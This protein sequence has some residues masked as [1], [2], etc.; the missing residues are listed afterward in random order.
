MCNTP[1]IERWH[2][3]CLFR[4]CTM[5]ITY[6]NFLQSLRKSRKRHQ[7]T[8][9]CKPTKQE[10]PEIFARIFGLLYLLDLL[11]FKTK[12]YDG[13]INSKRAS[14]VL[15]RAISKKF[16]WRRIFITQGLWLIYFSTRISQKSEIIRKIW[17]KCEL[18]A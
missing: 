2:K 11:S 9:P 12:L 14:L 4:G 18:S 16:R 15:K 8:F 17:V 5:Y 13:N 10:W 6:T 1:H 3:R 7:K